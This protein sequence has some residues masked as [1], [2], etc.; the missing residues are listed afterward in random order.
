MNRYNIFYQVHKGLRALLFETGIYLQQADFTREEEVAKVVEKAKEV[1]HVFDK[2]AHT[3]DSL[4]FPAIGA[5][6]PSVV[7]AFKSEHQED[8]KLAALLKNNLDV[9]IRAD[10]D[11]DRTESG[12]SLNILFAEFTAFNLRH[13]AKEESVLNRLLWRYYSDEE[14]IRLTQKIV[15]NQKPEDLARMNKWMLRGL[16]NNEIVMWLRNVKNNAPDFVFNALITLANQEM[17]ER[18]WGLVQEQLTEGL[19]LA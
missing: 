11:D 13:M 8:L 10:N 5:Y 17:G 9:L 2:H 15:S 18:R 7:D 19:L 12:K 4:V 1:A 14:L 16:N 6:E 3:E